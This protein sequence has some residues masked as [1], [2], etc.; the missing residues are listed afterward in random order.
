MIFMGWD[1]TLNRNYDYSDSSATP[2][3]NAPFTNKCADTSQPGGN[4]VSAITSWTDAGF[5][6]DKILMGLPAYGYINWSAATKLVHRS[7]EVF[8][9]TRFEQYL[10][11]LDRRR[12]VR[13]QELCPD[14]DDDCEADSDDDDSSS[15]ES[16][17]SG[18]DRQVMPASGNGMHGD[19]KTYPGTQ[20]QFN[21][22]F[23]W[24]V[25][26][27]DSSDPGHSLVGINGYVMA[28]D[29]CSSTVC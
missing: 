9:R 22:L 13:R 16:S 29:E 10:A 1:H 6:A 17:G 28:W 7:H 23:K 26:K 5:P 14:S 24:G 27:F 11:H 19:L 15:G 12:L 25:L 2:G 8:P 21:D 20:I 4:M 3:P 18:L